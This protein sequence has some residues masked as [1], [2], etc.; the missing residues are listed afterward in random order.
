MQELG[1][2]GRKF[3]IV[4]IERNVARRGNE[5]VRGDDG[6]GLNV[7]A[8]MS[9][10]ADILGSMVWDW[11]MHVFY[12]DA[13]NKA[14]STSGIPSSSFFFFFFFFFFIF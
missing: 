11:L 3:E 6:V 2:R 12:I 10:R 7:L 1:F 14:I 8:H 9:G 4:M 13:N 5:S